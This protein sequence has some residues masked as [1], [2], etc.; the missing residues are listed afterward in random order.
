[1]NVRQARFLF[2]I[3]FLVLSSACYAGGKL[4]LK[5]KEKHDGVDGSVQLGGVINTG[6]SNTKNLNGKFFIEAIKKPWLVDAGLEGEINKSNGKLNTEKLATIVEGRRLFSEQSYVFVKSS[7][8]YDKFAT[9]DIIVTETAG[10][11]YAIYESD[12]TLVA[13][14]S[15]GESRNI[16]SDDDKDRGSRTESKIGGTKE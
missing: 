15:D 16:N 2:F 9:F 5:K 3:L 1:M 7:A 11:G 4:I 14:E 8:A 6:N 12:M 13:I 10:Y